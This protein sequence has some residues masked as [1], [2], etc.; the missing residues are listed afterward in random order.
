VV[1]PQQIILVSEV[2]TEANDVRQL[3]PM[4]DQA[5]AMVELLL[6][7]D[8][9]LGA[10]AAD[11]GYWSEENAANQTEECEL[12]IATCQDRKQRVELREAASP[13]GRM[14]K[15]LS[16]RQRLQRSLRTKRG[17][18]NHAKR[19]VSVEPVIGPMKDRQSAGQVSMRGLAA[20][21]R[22]WH[23]HAAAH[24]LRNVHPGVC[25][26][27]RGR[28]SDERQA[29]EQGLTCPRK[30]RLR[31]PQLQVTLTSA[32]LSSL[33][34]SLLSDLTARMSEG[35]T[36]ALTSAG[37]RSKTSACPRTSCPL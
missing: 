16:A 15:G 20:C 37:L 23:V 34:D 30:G 21:R 12:F 14:P 28:R 8:V 18:T 6:G 2:T 4:L 24:T 9:V 5:Q 29:G 26:V 25:S 31:P 36:E 19:G 27:P 22:E 35:G 17:R 10:A 11:A 7:E 32:P 1:T 33:G 3:Q 13:R